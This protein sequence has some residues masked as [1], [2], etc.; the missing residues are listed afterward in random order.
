[1]AAVKILD[2]LQKFA[3][4]VCLLSEAVT[5]LE[6]GAEVHKQAHYI[7]DTYQVQLQPAGRWSGLLEC[8]RVADLSKKLS[9]R[10][11]RQRLKKVG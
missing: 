7:Y 8:S 6:P 3:A 1:M 4:A 11:G 9:A 10:R 5:A 2:W